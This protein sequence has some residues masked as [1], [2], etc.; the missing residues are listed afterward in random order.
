MYFQNHI[1]IIHNFNWSYTGHMG[2]DTF[3]GPSGRHPITTGQQQRHDEAPRRRGAA[4]RAAGS[5]G[6]GQ[7]VVGEDLGA[8]GRTPKE[9]NRESYGKSWG[10][11]GFTKI[12]E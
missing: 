9:F 8:M 5:E 4:Q 1:S 11:I 6:F 7:R 10:F 3:P 12:C 2:F